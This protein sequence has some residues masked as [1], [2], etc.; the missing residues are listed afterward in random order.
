MGAPSFFHLVAAAALLP[1]LSSF[2]LARSP[3]LARLRRAPPAR[4]TRTFAEM[5]AEATRMELRYFPLLAK[6][7]GP[8]LVLEHS[9]LP[10]AGNRDL[11][12]SIAAEWASL[13]PVTPF[14]QLPLL[15]VAGLPPIAQTAAIINYVG[16]TAGTEGQSAADYAWSQMLL[17]DAEDLYALMQKFVPT[18]Y[19]Q[20]SAAGVETAKGDIDDYHRFWRELLPTH[21]SKLERLL[22]ARPTATASATAS[23]TESPRKRARTRSAQAADAQAAG[24]Q[25]EGADAA[26][27]HASYSRASRTRGF[28]LPGELHLFSIPYQA[29][30]VEPSIFEGHPE[31]NVWFRSV[32]L[33]P[34]TARVIAGDSSM[35]ELQQ[36]FLTADSKDVCKKGDQRGRWG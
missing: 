25:A 36:Y 31:L 20:L 3:P 21:L 28:H 24:P 11:P 2:H 7:L 22:L 35:G 4:E 30:L 1:S 33:D 12:F 13:K 19:C 10:W 17:A 23:A 27:A 32:K 5:A 14:G 15:Q 16:R 6:G 18:V 29:C 26:D 8:T 9:G 34:R